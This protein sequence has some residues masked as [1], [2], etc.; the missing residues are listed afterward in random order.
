MKELIDASIQN[1]KG[2]SAYLNYRNRKLQGI[3]T[4]I[5]ELDKSILG[6]GGLTILEGG[7]GANK[8]SLALQIIYHNLKLGLPAIIIDAENG[9]GRIRSRLLCQANSLSES[10]LLTAT[11][12]ELRTYRDSVMH[13]P[14]YIYT[15]PVLSHEI[16][17]KRLDQ[18]F[19]KHPDK[20]GILLIDSLQALHALDSDQRINLEKW[21]YFF[22]RLKLMYDGQLTIICTSEINRSSYDEAKIGSAKGSNSVEF[23]AELL[24]DMRLDSR[25]NQVV[26]VN[27]LKHRDGIRGQRI[28][29]KQVLNDINNNRSFTFMLN[30]LGEIIE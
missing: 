18:M 15:E 24:L 20:P 4:G 8:S 5:E 21:M 9:E 13:L 14:L 11:V 3:T 6:L 17:S 25:D 22:D 27:V 29:L 12:P 30:G 16:L 23:K 10:Q 7:T 19:S 28:L 2:W 26:V 1:K